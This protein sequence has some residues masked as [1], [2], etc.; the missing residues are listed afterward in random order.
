MLKTRRSLGT[1][2]YYKKYIVTFHISNKSVI[3]VVSVVDI[4]A[5]GQH[6]IISKA[7]MDWL[8][9]NTLIPVSVIRKYVDLVPIAFHDPK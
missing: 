6:M 7:I 3:K 8:F 5:V 9:L 4:V 2:L 1:S